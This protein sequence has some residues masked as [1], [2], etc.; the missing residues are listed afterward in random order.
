[1]SELKAV[2]I[3]VDDEEDEKL[4]E[5]RRVREMIVRRELSVSSSPACDQVLPK[6]MRE[7]LTSMPQVAG[8]VY[9][10]QDKLNNCGQTSLRMIGFAEEVAVIGEDN[11]RQVNTLDMFRLVDEGKF[12]LSDAQET[13]RIQEVEAQAQV[14]LCTYPGKE[15]HWVVQAGGYIFD[16]AR[17]VM[18][19]RDY[20]ETFQPN[21]LAAFSKT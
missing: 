16:P 21:V 6:P 12:I 2:K 18:R 20:Q 15:N 3:G 10:Q 13:F 5:L 19:N 7:S 11:D 1:M 8:I 4:E 17:G 9:L 14:L